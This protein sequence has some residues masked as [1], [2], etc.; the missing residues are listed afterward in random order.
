MMLNTVLQTEIGGRIVITGQTREAVQS[1]VDF[2][3]D[4]IAAQPNGAASFSF[5]K[6]RADGTY[7]AYGRIE[8]PRY[9]ETRTAPLPEPTLSP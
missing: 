9:H 2:V 3:L 6:A 5:P 4:T 8:T 1:A 7:L